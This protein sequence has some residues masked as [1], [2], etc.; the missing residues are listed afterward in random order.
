MF[1]YVHEIKEAHFHIFTP[2]F[3]G[4]TLCSTA[5]RSDAPNW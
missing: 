3:Q 4:K 2:V 5:L 1:G